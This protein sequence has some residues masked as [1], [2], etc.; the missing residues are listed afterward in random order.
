MAKLYFYYSAM[1]AGKSTNLLQSSYNYQERGMGTLLLTPEIDERAGMGKIAS[2]IGLE[3]EAET[4]NQA[5]NL[6]ALIEGREV[7]PPIACVLI[8]EAQ[9]LTRPQVEQLAE[10]ADDLDIPVLCYGIR[11]D[12]QG[13]LFP[14]S[15]AL[16]GWA[17]NLTELK[18]ICHC[19]SKATMNLRTDEK[20]KAI[21]EGSQVEIGGNERYVSMCR[22]HFRESM[23]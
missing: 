1:N 16:L 5:D 13:N 22:K 10:V 3:A 19:G 7:D 4:F 15:A 18:T 11:T 14:G 8:D 9:F 2:R 20:G 12:F 21:K 6:H 23:R 17:D